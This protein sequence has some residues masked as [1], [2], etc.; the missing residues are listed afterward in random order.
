MADDLG[1]LPFAIGLSRQARRVIRQNLAISLGVIALL[2]LA[3]VSGTF[4][5]GVAVLF[6]EGSTLIVI[7][8]A[9]R[10]LRFHDGTEPRR[11]AGGAPQPHLG[12][13]AAASG[14]G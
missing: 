5:I 11:S 3:T 1:R 2:A 10:L 12:L 4:G 9:L 7:A 6:H 14:A 8:N 13:G